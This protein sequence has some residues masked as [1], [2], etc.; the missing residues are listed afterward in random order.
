MR[1]SSRSGSTCRAETA[2]DLRDFLFRALTF[3]AE[4]ERFRLA[5]IQVGATLENT[6][7]AL[8][9]ER[10]APFGVQRRNDAL[11]MARVYAVLFCFENE[12][13]DLIGE[14]LEE[15]LGS[16]WW[17]KMSPGVRR[18]AEK[19]KKTATKDSWLEGDKQDP[20]SFCDF[21]CL[22]DIIINSWE[23]FEDIIPSQQ[24]LKQRMDEL[25]KARNY[26]AHNRKL[27]PN[28]LRRIYMYVDDWNKLVGL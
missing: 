1:S 24:W 23:Y 14:R 22:G 18:E 13:R 16:E 3:E 6:E 20:L 11:E 17:G 4:A 15:R 28:E 26:V 12:V 21:G 8:L 5:G 19:R 7:S 27:L 25:E 9:L 2:R 10:I